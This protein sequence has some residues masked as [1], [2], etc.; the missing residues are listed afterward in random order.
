MC[1]KEKPYFAD[2]MSGL[3]RPSC[4]WHRPRNTFDL[5]DTASKNETNVTEFIERL[6]HHQR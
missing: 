1:Q 2:G 3:G 5:A 4:S 6:T